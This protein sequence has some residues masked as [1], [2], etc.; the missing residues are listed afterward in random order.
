MKKNNINSKTN[1]SRKTSSSKKSKPVTN[2]PFVKTKRFQGVLIALFFLFF[3]LV[4]R[5]AWLQFI[6]GSS[7]KER[8]YKQQT[9]N[10]II[11]TKRGSIYDSTGK[12]LAMSAQVDTVSINPGKI[13][14]KTDQQTKEKKKK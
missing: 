13:V 1:Q 4:I 10:Q 9:T 11:S 2:E 5:I 12:K 14:G 7:L 6:Q 8:A 3:G